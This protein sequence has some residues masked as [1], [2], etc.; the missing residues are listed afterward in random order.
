MIKVSNSLCHH[1]GYLD[2][3]AI[4]MSV[5]CGIHCLITPIL[6]A[7][8]PILSTTFW[9]SQDFH[10]WLLVLVIPTTSF[11][12]LAGCR[13]HKDK[14]VLILSIVALLMLSSV[15]LYETFYLC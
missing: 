14:I 2:K 5:L 13:K 1:H 8:L 10:L 4:S 7:F 15:A 11:A 6:I 12:V 3:L 9:V